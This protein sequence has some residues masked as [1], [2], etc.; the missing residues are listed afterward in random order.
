MEEYLTNHL[1]SYLEHVGLPSDPMQ[2]VGRKFRFFQEEFKDPSAGSRLIFGTIRNIEYEYRPQED[3]EDPVLELITDFPDG[4]NPD[5]LLHLGIIG[6]Q[7]NAEKTIWVNTWHVT[8]QGT[9]LLC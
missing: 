6:G 2:I 4:E 9:L 1:G 8:H 5:G 7:E 3:M